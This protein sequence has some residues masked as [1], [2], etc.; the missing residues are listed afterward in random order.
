MKPA[1][2]VGPS[3]TTL[4]C[5]RRRFFRVSLG[6]GTGTGTAQRPSLV[7]P[8]PYLATTAPYLASTLR[9]TTV[10][11]P[12]VSV[13]GARSHLRGHTVGDDDLLLARV[14]NALDRAVG[15]YERA[16]RHRERQRGTVV[17]QEGNSFEV[18]TTLLLRTCVISY[19]QHDRRVTR[20]SLREMVGGA[21]TVTSSCTDADVCARV[22]FLPTG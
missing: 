17:P 11:T 20:N 8:P 6:T 7:S 18:T 16:E 12:A 14:H 3:T 15:R 22:R 1:C 19:C 9:S 2:F 5:L 4:W 21:L 13:T 10:G